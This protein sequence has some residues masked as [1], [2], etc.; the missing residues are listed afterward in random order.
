MFR[1]LASAFQPIYHMLGTYE[2]SDRPD[3][4]KIF[5]ILYTKL[6][7]I[8]GTL[9][10]PMEYDSIRLSENQ[11]EEIKFSELTLGNC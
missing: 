10:G 11:V 6:K 3:Y 7:E 1:F 5:D 2:Y 9:T 8:G 4:A